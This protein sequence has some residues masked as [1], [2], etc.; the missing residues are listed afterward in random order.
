M[1]LQKLQEI[2]LSMA[3]K[4]KLFPVIGNIAEMRQYWKLRVEQKV[5][6]SMK[7]YLNWTGVKTRQSSCVTA[8]GIPPTTLPILSWSLPIIHWGKRGPFMNPTGQK[9]SLCRV[10]LYGGESLYGPNPLYGGVCVESPPPLVNRRTN[11]RENI[12]HPLDARG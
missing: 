2:F 8:R 9:G 11:T 3:K 12:P 5:L 6:A 1:V 4:R 7:I 10:P